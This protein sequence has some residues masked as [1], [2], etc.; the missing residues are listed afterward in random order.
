MIKANRAVAAILIFG[1]PFTYHAQLF[2]RS[3]QTSQL[4]TAATQDS[5]VRFFYQ[6][7]PSSNFHVALLLRVVTGSDARWNTAPLYDVGRTAYITDSEMQD[8]LK[9]LSRSGLSWTVSNSVEP[10]ETYKTIHSFGGMNVKVLS[11]RA[12]AKASIRPDMIC[13]TLAPLDRVLHTPRAL[14]EFKFFRTQYH[15]RVTNF[16]PKAYPDRIP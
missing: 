5:V 1:F 6:P 3:P 7:N 13:V 10:L 8:F 2:S 12:T 15:C 4:P 9:G 14:W 16:D 11:S